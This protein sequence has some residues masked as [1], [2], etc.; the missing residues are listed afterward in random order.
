MKYALQIYGVFRTYSHCLPQILNYINYDKLDIDVYILS[1]K[2]DGYSQV[3]EQRI[4]D[5]LGQHKVEFRYI[6]NYDDDTHNKENQLCRH[7]YDCVSDA[8]QNIQ[9][10]LVTNEF[11][12]RM[13]F[14]R[15]LNNQMRKDSHINYDWVIRTRFDIGYTTMSNGK[16]LE[17][18]LKP[19]PDKT[20]FV[21]PDIFSCGSP[22]MIDLESEL[23]NHWPYIYNQYNIYGRF[24][25][26]NNSET[27]RK[28]F[29]MSEMNLIQFLESYPIKVEYIPHDLKITRKFMI[30][31]KYNGDDIYLD[32]IVAVYYGCTDHWFDITK[33]FVNLYVD[34]Y[35]KKYKCS[36]IHIGNNLVPVDPKPY[37]IKQ[38]VILTLEGQ[39]Y[40]YPENN[41]VKFKYKLYHTINL[42]K[43]HI[44]KA[45]YGSANKIIDI[46]PN[47]LELLKKHKIFHVTN[48]ILG[49]DP[50]PGEEKNICFYF[51]DG[52]SVQYKEYSIIRVT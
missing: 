29:F 5:M 50:S 23:I 17:C 6:E 44:I 51:G 7:Y 21:F 37:T 49:K 32:H 48:G 1:Q 35:N 31:N 27:I 22:E 52:S 26:S 25:F 36:T 2:D 38:L 34:K 20:I 11:V 19:P 13:W 33:T 15:W 3:D 45:T 9:E 47:I 4:R 10:D 39:E 46:T 28:W 41:D 24:K 8:K 12:S 14:R 18:L 30:N 40:V 42:S 43:K 16:K